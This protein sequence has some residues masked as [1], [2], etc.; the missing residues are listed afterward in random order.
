MALCLELCV[1]YE[2]SDGWRSASAGI[3]FDGHCNLYLPVY[4]PRQ[5]GLSLLCVRERVCMGVCVSACWVRAQEPLLQFGM[6]LV[7]LRRVTAHVEH[8]H[9]S[10]LNS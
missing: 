9:I 7:V 2:H 5:D 8:V 4:F 3:N 6:R 10:Q 1:R